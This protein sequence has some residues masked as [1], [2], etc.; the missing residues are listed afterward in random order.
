VQTFERFN[1]PSLVF[2]SSLIRME[3]GTR[4]ETRNLT[5]ASSVDKVEWGWVSCGSLSWR[6]ALWRKVE[7]KTREITTFELVSHAEKVLFCFD[8]IPLD[9]IDKVYCVGWSWLLSCLSTV[10][11]RW[12]TNSS[13]VSVKFKFFK[14]LLQFCPARQCVKIW[15]THNLLKKFG[16]SFRVIKFSHTKII[17]LTKLSCRLLNSELKRML[18]ATFLKVNWYQWRSVFSLKLHFTLIKILVNL[19][20]QLTKC[21]WRG[22]LKLWIC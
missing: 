17:Y 21:L 18:G 8:Q 4:H 3:L 12:T 2:R 14:L 6:L 9:W 5:L 22:P 16:S 15:F 10:S 7:H 11:K 19:V 1:V 20:N 13:L